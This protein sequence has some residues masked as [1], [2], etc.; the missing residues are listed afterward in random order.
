MSHKHGRPSYFIIFTVYV[1]FFYNKRAG[2]TISGFVKRF[3]HGAREIEIIFTIVSKIGT[4]T[5]MSGIYA[6]NKPR[7]PNV[8]ALT[9]EYHQSVF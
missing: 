7:C 8:G 3:P 9:P 1:S 4:T 2:S 5:A 6:T